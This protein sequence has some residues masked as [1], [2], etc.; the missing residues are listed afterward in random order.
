VS[1]ALG[2][3]DTTQSSGGTSSNATHSS[4]FSQDRSDFYPPASNSPS[5]GPTYF[6]NN[7]G[8][9]ISAGEF[10]DSAG[11]SKVKYFSNPKNMKITG[12]RYGTLGRTDTTQSFGGTLSNAT[13]S[14]TFSQ[15]GSDYY[16]S[17][18]NERYRSSGGTF[19]ASAGDSKVKY[20]SDSKNMKITGGR[21][22]TLGRTDTTQS[23]GGTS[24]NATHSSTFSQDGSDGDSHPSRQ[25]TGK[26]EAHQQGAQS[27]DQFRL[28]I[29]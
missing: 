20:F 1:R 13:H 28:T 7:E 12:G 23:S 5:I 18:N 26:I 21:Y 2:R 4:T 17:L 6:S 3:T 25:S 10:I 24:S 29:F 19:I 11:D 22:G 8:D 15:D 16:F 9:E 27:S 14:S